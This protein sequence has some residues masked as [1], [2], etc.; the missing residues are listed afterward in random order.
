MAAKQ[1]ELLHMLD[2]ML[3]MPQVAELVLDGLVYFINREHYC[4]YYSCSGRF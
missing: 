4:L 1:G 3:V 2:E